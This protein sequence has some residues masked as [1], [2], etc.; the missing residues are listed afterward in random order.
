MIGDG[1]YLNTIFEPGSHS[2]RRW[3]HGGDGK[4]DVWVRRERPLLILTLIRRLGTLSTT[5]TSIN[6]DFLA[7]CQSLCAFIYIDSSPHLFMRPLPFVSD[8]DI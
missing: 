7:K 1:H 4:P 8:G 6:I 3:R 2:C 5:T